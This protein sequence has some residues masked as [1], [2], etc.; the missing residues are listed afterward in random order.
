[1]YIYIYQPGPY[2]ISHLFLHRQPFQF[3]MVVFLQ[4]QIFT[5]KINN[6][7]AWKILKLPAIHLFL[8]KSAGTHMDVSENSGI[9]KMDGL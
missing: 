6:K 2:K 5:L 7:I 9:P 4:I 8:A 3:G 1:M